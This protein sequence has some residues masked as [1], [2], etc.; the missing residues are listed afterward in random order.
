M[1]IDGFLTDRSAIRRF[2]LA[3]RLVP[4]PAA[5]DWEFR[6]EVPLPAGMTSLPF[7]V[8]DAAGNIT[9]GEIQL[10]PAVNEP[11]R[12]G[13]IQTLPRWTTL[14]PDTVVADL[15]TL[16]TVASRSAPPPDQHAPV[17]KLHGL[18]EEQTV[19]DDSIYI[20]GQVTDAS[21][22][23]ALAI[24]GESLWRRHT[25]QMF[26]GQKFALQMGDNT[27][28]VEAFDEAGNK[29]QHSIVVRREIQAVKRWVRGCG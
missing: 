28:L 29:A 24:N 27:F 12:D 18:V 22:I 1:H 17:I 10:T 9:R 4:L 7:E 13:A 20:E 2:V 11:G 3:G 25:R 21:M 8:E 16:Y 19:Y 6:Q 5:T 26:F 15:P 23:T 14:H